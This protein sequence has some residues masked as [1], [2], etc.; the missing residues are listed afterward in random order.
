M[1][2]KQ[3]V[4]DATKAFTAAG[5]AATALEVGHVLSG[6]TELIVFGVVAA[7]LAFLGVYNTPDSRSPNK[8]NE[9]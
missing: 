9:P 2:G 1:N 4:A 6:S 7:G 3:L 8:K 5:A